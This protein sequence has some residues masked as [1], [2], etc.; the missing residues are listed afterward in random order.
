MSVGAGGFI[1]YLASVLEI[2]IFFKR[3]TL[4]GLL[5]LKCQIPVAVT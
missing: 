5:E 1:P 2:L 3:Q 4:N